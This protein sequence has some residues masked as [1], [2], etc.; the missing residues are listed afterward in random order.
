LARSGLLET[1]ARDSLL[2]L[3]IPSPDVGVG[4]LGFIGTSAP[5]GPSGTRSNPVSSG[6]IS[7]PLRP[8]IPTPGSGRISNPVSSALRSKP[9]RPG[10]ATRSGIIS[11]PVGSG[12]NSNPVSSENSGRGRTPGILGL[13]PGGPSGSISKPFRPGIPTPSS[14]IN[15]KPVSVTGRGRVRRLAPRTRKGAEIR[16]A[17]TPTFASS[18]A[19]PGLKPSSRYLA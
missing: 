3:G 16:P 18:S 6:I 14:G 1:F 19:T 13:G 17:S 9:L 4:T 5:P 2:V 8:G 7:K 10:M 15:S 11:K 12:I